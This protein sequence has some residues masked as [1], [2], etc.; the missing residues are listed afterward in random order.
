MPQLGNSGN[1]RGA[2][3]LLKLGMRPGLIS[4]IHLSRCSVRLVG[5]CCAEES[6]VAHIVSIVLQPSFGVGLLSHKKLE[7][8]A[9]IS[10]PL[11]YSTK[12]LHEAISN[13][14]FCPCARGWKRDIEEVE[15][16]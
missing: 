2:H 3:I 16:S 12:H 4:D 5:R 7:A 13:D 9:G 6:V 10:I 8:A 1:E 15:S 14:R 11:G